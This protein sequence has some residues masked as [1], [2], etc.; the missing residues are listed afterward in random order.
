M[1]KTVQAVL[2]DALNLDSHARAEIAVELIASLD[3]P[4]DPDVEVAWEAEAARRLAAYD[5]GALPVEEWD[6]LKARIEREIFGR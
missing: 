4:A 5:A 2:A 6:V 1:A 3:G